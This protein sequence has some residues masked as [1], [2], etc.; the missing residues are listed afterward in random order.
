MPNRMAICK[1]GN[2]ALNSGRTSLGK[3]KMATFLISVFEV[4][5]KRGLQADGRLVPFLNTGLQ[6]VVDRGSLGFQR[7]WLVAQA[8]DRDL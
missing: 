3:V 6:E 2:L 8:F 5:V 1:K 4:H 7:M